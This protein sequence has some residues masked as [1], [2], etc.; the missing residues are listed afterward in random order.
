MKDFINWLRNNDKIGK[1]VIWLF[2]ITIG[3][4][5]V[6]TALTSLGLPHYQLNTTKVFDI[7]SNKI[8]DYTFTSIMCILNF[9]SITLLVFRIS[10]S[11]KLFKHAVVYLIINWI[12][13]EILPFIL[14]QVFIIVY[15]VIF[16]Y[17]YSNKKIKYMGYS[18]AAYII[19]TLIQ[20]VWYFINGQFIDYEA[21]NKLTKCLLSLDYFIT[22]S[23][24]ILVKEFYLKKR[25]ENDESTRRSNMHMVVWPIQ[26]RKDICKKTSKKSIKYSQIKNKNSSKTKK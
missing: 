3:L 9:Y 1:V 4:I 13:S 8:L 23:L 22:V 21:L 11:K 12:I 24:M 15:I 19:V 10:E 26:Q 2:I 14:V 16:C 7:N 18:F 17:Y 6:N 20:G 25:G 5:I